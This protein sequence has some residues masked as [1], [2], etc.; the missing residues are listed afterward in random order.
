[1]W[2]ELDD[3]GVKPLTTAE[4]VDKVMAEKAG[5]VMILVNS[6]CGCAAGHARPGVALALQNKVIPDRLYTVFAGVDRQATQRAREYMTGMP[7]SSPSVALFKDGELVYMLHRRQIEQMD[8]DNVG[9]HLARVFDQY[10]QSPGP[11]VSADTVARAFNMS[12]G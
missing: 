5:T 12:I 9:Q 10:C 4:A 8:M 6:V 3:I 2:K 11:S 1:M 7:S